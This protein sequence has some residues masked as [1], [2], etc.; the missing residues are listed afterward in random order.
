[1]ADNINERKKD[2][3]NVSCL[4]DMTEIMLKATLNTI[5]SHRRFYLDGYEARIYLHGKLDMM[6]SVAFLT[7]ILQFEA[8]HYCSRQFR[9][10]SG[11][12]YVQ[13]NLA[14]NSPLLYP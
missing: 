9:A 4:S 6:C 2:M 10:R 5:Q 3:D 13:P 14:L 7:V 11:C 8:T 12:T 1:M